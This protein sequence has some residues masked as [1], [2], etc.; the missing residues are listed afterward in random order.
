MNIPNLYLPTF[1]LVAQGLTYS[2][3]R[4]RLKVQ[5]Y[6]SDLKRLDLITYVIK[7]GDVLEIKLTFKGQM[8]WA[9]NQDDIRAKSKIYG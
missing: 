2:Q 9:A 1:Y 6:L 7:T 3:I 8:I 5:T 4:E